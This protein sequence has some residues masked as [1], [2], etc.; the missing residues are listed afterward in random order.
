MLAGIR[1]QT[2]TELTI[3]QPTQTRTIQ[4]SPTNTPTNEPEPSSAI[5]QTDHPVDKALPEIR[6]VTEI[7]S[8]ILLIIA[9]ALIAIFSAIVGLRKNN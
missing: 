1:A 6:R 9:I 8:T 5:N 7:P 4:P 3:S 2:K